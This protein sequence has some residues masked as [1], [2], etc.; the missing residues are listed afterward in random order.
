MGLDIHYYSNIKEVKKFTGDEDYDDYEIIINEQYYKYQL[1]SLCEE[2]IY[3]KTNES[4][5]GSFRAGSYSGYNQWR[6]SLAIM[7]GYGSS[8]YVWKNF[9]KDR[10]YIKLQKIN[11]K[12]IKMKPFYELIH[13]SDCEGYIGTET[14]KKLYQD[15]VD[16]EDKAIDFDSS[17]GGP[18]SRWFYERYKEWK[19]AFEVASDNGVV[20]FH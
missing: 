16:F 5:E 13:F 12:D 3:D 10:R 11:K 15:F 17:P 2:F 14:S 7:A 1:G 19:N 6:N 9:E 18:T 4:I 8:E 20:C